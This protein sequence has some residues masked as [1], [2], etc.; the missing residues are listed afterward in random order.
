M[1]IDEN[2]IVDNEYG[3]KQID[4]LDGLESVR[5]RPGM[6]IG[7]TSQKGLTHLIFEVADNSF[8]EFVAGYGNEIEI[9]IK[10]DCS[11]MI[12]DYGRGIPVGPHHRWKNDD[13]TPMDTLTGILTKL[14]AGGKFGQDDSGYKVSAGLHGV[15]GSTM[16]EIL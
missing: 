15:S 16:G 3:T 1:K 10:D 7:S 5:K 11:V 9:H 4:S 13:D 2:H 8:D 6:Y 14:H 12:K